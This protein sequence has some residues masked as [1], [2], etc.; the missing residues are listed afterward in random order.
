MNK[1]V[2]IT[3]ASGLIGSHLS[4]ELAG[5]YDLRLLD[6]KPIPVPN[7]IVAD[8]T[9]INAMRA[10][11]KGVDIVIHL[12]GSAAVDSPWD[13]VLH[14]NIIGTYTVFEAAHQGGVQQVIFASSNHAVGTYETIDKSEIEQGTLM[15]NYLI[16]VRPDSLYGVSK[17]FGEALGRYYSD[18]QGLRVIC[19][20]IGS[21]THSNKPE[22]DLVGKAIWQ[23]ERDFAQ[24]VRKCIEATDVKFDIFYGVSNDPHRFF[25]IE[26]ARKVIGYV[27]Q[28]G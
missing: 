24:M 6:E 26:H 25:D 17:C 28:D 27:P 18:H 12:A 8:I 7:S 19:I 10:A 21:I 2:L 4:K 23:S 5:T 20:R 14:N 11:C 16:P 9:D 15:L 13:A 1:T 3:G 22:G